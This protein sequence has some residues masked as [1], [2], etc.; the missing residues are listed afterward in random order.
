MKSIKFPVIL[1]LAVAIV[2]G[3]TKKFEDYSQNPNQPLP[4]K[5]PPGIILKSILNDLVV[6]PGGDADKAGQFIASNYVYYGTNQYWTGSAS[7]N[8]GDLNNTLQMEA[9]AR[10][11]AGSDNNPYNALG[12]FFRAFFFLIRGSIYIKSVFNVSLSK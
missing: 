5:V 1:F 4:G 6:F 3:C 10:R 11:L 12:L 9:E 7:L 2:A 8:Y